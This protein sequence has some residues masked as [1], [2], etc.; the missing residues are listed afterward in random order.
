M[1]RSWKKSASPHSRRSGG[2]EVDVLW[3]SS[4]TPWIHSGTGNTAADPV[5]ADPDGADNTVG[6]A[7][8]DVRLTSGSSAIDAGC[9]AE[10]PDDTFDV[11]RDGDADEPLS[12]DLGRGDLFF[13]A[14]PTV[15]MGAYEYLNIGDDLGDLEPTATG[16]P[17]PEPFGTA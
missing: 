10:V 4:G 16:A 9:N 11:D 3:N 17:A 5:L 12:L 14:G 2:Y 7:D 1:G 6:T 8:D 13:G 15:D